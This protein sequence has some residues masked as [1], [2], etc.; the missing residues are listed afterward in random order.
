VKRARVAGVVLVIALAL[1][2]SAHAAEVTTAEFQTLVERA[3]DDDRAALAELRRVDAVDGQDVNVRG[4]LR[5]ARGDDLEVRLRTLGDSIPSQTE[6]LDLD[7]QAEA[8]EVLAE[9][10]F[11]ADSPRPLRSFFEWLGDLLPDLGGIPG[12]PAVAWLVLAALV[13]VLATVFGRRVLTRRIETSAAAQAADAAR[14]DPRAL[15][16]LADEAEAAGELERA[17]RL[18]FRAGL[19]RL[20]AGGAIDYRPSISTREVSR[21]LRSEDFDA[22]ALT[23]DDVVYGGR[24][25][26]DADV[27]ESR[28]RWRAVV[29]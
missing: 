14:E 6:P 7:P 13:V 8:R 17:L 29:N 28:S 22:L 4:A 10:R 16:R 1:P 5:G 27:E 26:Q 24:E 18:R 9:D 20:D 23:F 11:Q 19:L 2:G 21:K 15:E 12:P 3:I 25:A